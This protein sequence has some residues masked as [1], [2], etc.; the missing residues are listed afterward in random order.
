ME[1]F[2]V[3]LTCV[4]A[5]DAPSADCALPL[6]GAAAVTDVAAAPISILRLDSS[7]WLGFRMWCLSFGP[8]S[9]RLILVE[10][11]GDRRSGLDA[12]IGKSLCA[13][14]IN[15]E[16]QLQS[17]NGCSPLLLPTTA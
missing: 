2:D 4:F 5:G 13:S 6:V 1:T 17:V 7:N 15:A 11:M 3:A 14:F 10:L 9:R 12:G 16:T 8:S